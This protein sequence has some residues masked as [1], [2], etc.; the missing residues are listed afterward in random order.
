MNFPK[1]KYHPFLA[2]LIVESQREE[3]E[4]GDEWADTPFASKAA[5]G[6]AGDGS[7]PTSAGMT[8][9][10]DNRELF[11]KWL[12]YEELNGEAPSVLNLLFNA[13]TARGRQGDAELFVEVPNAD[14]AEVARQKLLVD[15]KELG[16]SLH[17]RTGAEKIQA[18]IDAKLAEG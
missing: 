13:F 11:G 12:E 17:P 6:Q 16:L 5:P 3:D 1:W 4:L 18:A 2:A 10:V 14:D 9:T 8:P 15:A 7:A